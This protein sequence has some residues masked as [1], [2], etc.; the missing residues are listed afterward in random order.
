MA[1]SRGVKLGNP[2]GAEALRRAGKGGAPLRAAIARNADRHAR[3]LAPVVADIRAGG[4]ISLRAIAGE[5]NA[6][7][8]LTRRG[9]RWHVSTVTNLL[10]RLELREPPDTPA[11]LPTPEAELSAVHPY[12]PAHDPRRPLLED[13]DQS[14][15]NRVAPKDFRFHP[16]TRRR[17]GPTLSAARAAP[18]PRG[19]CRQPPDRRHVRA[20]RRHTRALDSRRTRRLLRCGIG[21]ACRRRPCPCALR[22]AGPC[23]CRA[24]HCR[25]GLAIGASYH[26]GSAQTR[27]ARHGHI[28]IGER[29]RVSEDD[30][31]GG[32]LAPLRQSSPPGPTS[33]WRSERRGP[34]ARSR[35][36]RGAAP[37]GR[38]GRSG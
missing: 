1:R 13:G 20:C 6:R 36:R 2:N 17:A 21:R 8:M 18:P 11:T 23:R 29:C 7:G 34:P 30:H 22:L 26:A 19:Q 28:T 38:S 32:K 14:C 5:L 35:G 24:R 37:A 3:D 10:E 27:Q 16:S 25:R 12:F 33:R 15:S 4:A 9:G 31:M